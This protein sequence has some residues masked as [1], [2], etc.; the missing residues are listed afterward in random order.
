MKY[1]V[2]I[3]FCLTLFQI[4]IVSSQVYERN[5]IESK[6][7][8]VY[9]ETALEI[10]N[11]YGN[12][13]L[14]T[15]DN[16]SVKIVI[17]IRVKANKKSKA[18]KIFDY[19][20]VE[21]SS[22]KYYIIATTQFKQNQNSFWSEVTDLANTIF[23]GN[24]KVQ[25]YYDIYL[26][27]DMEIKLE[28]KFGNIYF[29]DYQGEANI[30]LSNGDLKANYLSG[31]TNINLNFGNASINRINEGKIIIKYAEIEIDS[32]SN[33][34]IE[35]KSST[36]N[37]SKAEFLNIDSSR[38][39]YYIGVLGNINGKSSFSY[40]TIKEVSDNTK[41][42][43]EYGEMKFEDISEG[44]RIIE[45]Q[46]EYT[47]IYLNFPVT[48]SCDLTINY[49]GETGI[50]Y[51][52]H[53]KN[54]K[55]ETVDKKEDIYKSYGVIGDNSANKGSVNLNVKSGKVVIKDIAPGK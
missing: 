38:D 17:D 53:Y 47:D 18:D 23:S 7:F 15:W 24:T 49:S 22:T 21:F 9:K 54:I 32:V 42:I 48:I 2:I 40:L 50:Y 36:I 52:E 43:T 34:E 6:S 20:D 45:L 10:N 35:S 44:F 13:H 25:I 29:S 1:K 4:K 11:K 27:N 46:S 19:I 51:P 33:L 30:N 14:F 28:N 8:K 39:K 26:P 55:K 31:Y 12:I 16:D 37:I 5:K 41:L 3:L